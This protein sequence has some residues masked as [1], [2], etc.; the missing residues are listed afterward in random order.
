MSKPNPSRIPSTNFAITH[1]S[2]SHIQ[3]PSIGRSPTDDYLC[4]WQHNRSKVRQYTGEYKC[5]RDL[6]NQ[7]RAYRGPSGCWLYHDIAAE[8]WCI[9]NAVNDCQMFVYDSAKT[10]DE[11]SY[12]EWKYLDEKQHVQQAARGIR[13]KEVYTE[14]DKTRQSLCI[15]G[16]RR[17]HLQAACMG[18]YSEVGRWR[19][20]SD[21]V[22]MFKQA[23]CLHHGNSPGPVVAGFCDCALIVT[24]QANAGSGLTRQ[25]VVG[26]F[27]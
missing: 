16:L 24:Y 15:V 10:P 23:T 18:M 25:I 11:I 14:D 6:I 5:Q 21:G 7:R 9:G 22:P 26:S 13:I 19:Q 20:S 3:P 27:R 8:R 4:V 2:V 12:E 17:T 1:I